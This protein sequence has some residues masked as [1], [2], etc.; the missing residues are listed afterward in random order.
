[1]AGDG[2]L[3]QH[4]DPE[5]FAELLAALSVDVRDDDPL[6][7]EFGRHYYPAVFGD[8]LRD[9]SFAVVGKDGSAFVVEC[10][11]LDGTLGR[12]GMPLRVTTLGAPTAK[13]ERRLLREVL[14]E[15]QR[16]AE[17]DEASEITIAGDAPSRTLSGLG[18]A[19]MGAEGKPGVVL[20][21]CVDLCETTA[22]L[23]SD[24][25]DSYRSLVN[26]G[27]RSLSMEYCNEARPDRELFRSYE[28]LHEQVV[29][30]RT[31]SEASW[32]VMFDFVAR[33][34]GELALAS[35]EGE[36]VAG[37]LVFDGAL[38][39]QY[40]SAA[41]VREHFDHS[42]AHWPLFNAIVRARERGLRWFDVGPIRHRDDVGDKEASIGFFKRG[43]TNRI[44]TRIKWNLPIDG[45][46]P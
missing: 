39:T 40:A 26:W 1:M 44:E 24:L 37:M 20:H 43:F 2:I 27:E 29:G 32:N 36:L 28:V 7:G 34:R 21:A 16:I 9:R 18:R 12:F 10:D 35:L 8:R 30:R 22:A 17:A 31:R 3:S 15:L 14:A 13:V 25:R 42:L 19:C 41:Y 46:T 23:R 33:G 5:S 38:T 11:V 4:A 45:R 6:Y